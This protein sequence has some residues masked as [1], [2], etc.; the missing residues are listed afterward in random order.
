MAVASAEAVRLAA[1]SGQSVAR[2]AES[3]AAPMAFATIG[4]R[5]RMAVIIAE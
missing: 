5:K 4:K 2:L 1:A 3:S